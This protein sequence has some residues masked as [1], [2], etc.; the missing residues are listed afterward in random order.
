M[1]PLEYLFDP[2]R[3]QHS[4]VMKL[5][6]D[7]KYDAIFES[8]LVASLSNP[9]IK[10][11]LE[12]LV[13]DSLLLKSMEEHNFYGLLN[14]QKKYIGNNPNNLE[15]MINNNMDVSSDLV[16]FAL[17]HGYR[18][19]DEFFRQNAS[20]FR[21]EDV[22]NKL[23]DLKIDIPSDLI[24]KD[25]KYLVGN[26]D[27]SLLVRLLDNGYSPSK[28]FIKS[29]TA[30]RKREVVK[31]LFEHYDF[32]DDE[33]NSTF[34]NNPLARMEMISNNPS[35][36]SSISSSDN[37][38]E[39]LWLEIIKNGK[40]DD[41]KLT[42]SVTG[43]YLLMSK[44]IKQDPSLIKKVQI[45]EKKQ[46]EA[47][48]N[49]AIA[50]GYI[51]TR[52][53]VINSKYIQRSYILM[54]HAIS[55]R[56]ELIKYV[57]YEDGISP[58]EFNDLARYAVENGYIPSIEDIDDNPGLRNSFDV[59]KQIVIR[60]PNYIEVCTN[61]V[62]HPDWL[63]KIALNNGYKLTDKKL[64]FA[65]ERS[66]SII[67][68][69]FLQTLTL[70]SWD[71]L[72]EFRRSD[73]SMDL[74]NFFI[75]HNCKEEDFFVLFTDNYEVM[76]EI[77]KKKPQLVIE[78]G[79]Y[80]SRQ[81]IDDLCML[82]LDLGYIPSENDKVFSR[83]F[84]SIKYM[85]Q[86]DPNYFYKASLFDR[87]SLFH[88]DI[89]PQSQYDELY[90]VAVKNG[91]KPDIGLIMSD[92]LIRERFYSNYDVMCQILLQDPSYILYSNIEDDEKFNNLCLLALEL[93]YKPDASDITYYPKLASNFN[94]IK[95]VIQRDPSSIV[96]LSVSDP[97]K[98]EELLKIALESGLDLSFS[99]EEMLKVFLP[100]P[101]DRLKTFINNDFD[102][103]LIE[104]ARRLYNGNEDIVKTLNSSFLSSEIIE[105]FTPLQIEIL[106]CYP[107]I[108]KRIVDLH[109]KNDY[110]RNLV[111]DL[112]NEFKDN[113][114]WIGI[115]ENVMEN[116][117][118]SEFANLLDDLK[119]KKLTQD[120]KIRL[121]YLLNTN[122]HLDISSF[123]ELENIDEIRNN[124]I[125]MLVKRNTVGSLKTAYLEKVFGI[126]LDKAMN[127]VKI[128][129]ESLNS[130]A[131]KHLPDDDKKLFSMLN[132]MKNVLSVNSVEVLK[133][134]VD[135][136]DTIKHSYDLMTVFESKLKQTFTNE[137]NKSF[138]K[139]NVED[140][141]TNLMDSE[142]D[143]DVYYAAGVNGDK[144]MRMMITS[145]G[146]YTNVEEPDDYYASWNVNK[147]ASHGVCCSYI[148]EK[149]LGTARIKY[150][151]FG[152]SDY[153][154]G[155]LHLAAPYDLDSKSSDKDFKINSQRAPMYLM[156]DDLLDYTRHTHNEIVWERRLLGK[157]GNLK[158][159]QPSYIVYFV[160]NFEDRL[161][162]VEAKK[163]WESVKKAAKDFGRDGKS[164]PIMV[165]EREKIADN[166]R[167]MIEDKIKQFSETLDKS[168]IKSI[169]VDYESNYAGNR[170]YHPE[171]STKYFPQ[172][173]DLNETVVGR[174]IEIIN[175]SAII[176]KEGAMEC[177]HE[178]YNVVESERKKYDN[179]EAK[180]WEGEVMSSFNIAEA[181]DSISTSVEK[182]K[183]GNLSV[184][185]TISEMEEANRQFESSDSKYLDQEVIDSQ[186]SKDDVVGLLS[187]NGMASAITTI[188]KE[189]HHEGINEGLKA[190]GQRHIKDVVLFSG[191]IGQQVLSNPEDVKLLLLAA[192]YHDVGRTR[193]GHE[194]HA[195][196]SAIVTKEK[197][198][199][200]CSKD[201]LAIITTA[202]EYHEMDRKD[203]HS[204]EMFKY[205]A[206]KNGV[207]ADQLDRAKVISEIL[208]DADALDRTR[209]INRARLNASYLQ[210]PISR[211]LIKFSAQLQENYA[212]NDLGQYNCDDQISVLL[213][214]NTPQSVLR[215]IRH[216]SNNKTSNSDAVAFIDSWSQMESIKSGGKY[217]K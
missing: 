108:Q 109:F 42:T 214:G 2:K 22:L 15:K 132:N 110:K 163:Q 215:T 153:E 88:K 41:E 3:K 10:S 4:Q 154:A 194:E 104:R 72:Y 107:I 103:E 135:S 201:E 114:Q 128:Y 151:C 36:I 187:L 17:E 150:C 32:E 200:V 18:P 33:I 76:K 208:K 130:D 217:G 172:K 71:Y 90:E 123:N 7:K 157:N 75:E 147:V 168:L 170:D 155:S 84:E 140:K 13:D 119:D 205:V 179:V 51:P 50:M 14:Y 177:L 87:G 182:L 144:K 167:K 189:I 21:S 127:L 12:Q 82:A 116:I 156:P 124:Y 56:P 169:V 118:S 86:K 11:K 57:A 35:L 93:G 105:H 31:K 131:I 134:Y 6:K 175:Y 186:L 74:Y 101:S 137:F 102:I 190:H 99:Q 160:D 83:G 54:K 193:D 139:P 73:M 192:K 183:T 178:L 43:N 159:K 34:Y 69:R 174:L 191:I 113:M 184:V 85:L 120:N 59:I 206:T 24:E 115:L 27:G 161:T 25:F 95:A 81:Q 162:D 79:E 92:K 55:Y 48:E 202:I 111:Y 89:I 173:M 197:L 1:N 19:D 65:I 78:A 203:P 185:S 164:L 188:E 64:P 20:W 52:S 37:D 30:F 49:M 149:N 39:R 152:F 181:L 80:L 8:N 142:K 180:S 212:L 28:D 210:F 146:A 70:P 133:K 16:C 209:F 213:Q 5:I 96:N 207:S 98:Q 97:A 121:L 60:D 100:I 198:K 112:V 47:L 196:S 38:F 53:E 141:I 44:L 26:G 77:V 23:I 125:K 204:D 61:F 211:Q 66:E 68:E 166:Q 40:V 216:N 29:G 165:V 62:E 106:S 158:K 148:G 9:K 176:N 195:E 94:M 145:I 117:N 67:K 122:N 138:A 58:L 136:V 199:D 46:R 45:F 126:D 171:I 91:F 129:G 143:Y 63:A